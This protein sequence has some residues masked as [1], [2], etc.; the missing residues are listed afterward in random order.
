MKI[1]KLKSLV[2]T[3]N[4]LSEKTS[5]GT[6]QDVRGALGRPYDDYIASS[7][8]VFDHG[9]TQGIKGA[10]GFTYKWKLQ[11]PIA[12]ISSFE[13]VKRRTE[14]TMEERL[15]AAIADK[16]ATEPDPRDA[17]Y[18]SGTADVVERKIKNGEKYI[19]VAVEMV[20]GYDK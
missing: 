14:K 17:Q 4:I 8:E 11:I 19:V 3:K 13:D 6:E 20:V 12:D 16:L 18:T 5:R 15:M 10:K 1:I 2:E 7:I 9:Q